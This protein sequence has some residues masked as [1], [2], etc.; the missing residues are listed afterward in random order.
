VDSMGDLLLWG[1]CSSDC[2][3]VAETNNMYVHPEN[4]VG[5]CK[6]GVPNAKR[7]SSRIVGGKEAKNGEFPWQVAILR[8]TTPSAQYCGGTLVSDRHVVTAAHCVE[9]RALRK[10][11]LD[12]PYILIGDTTLAI[13]N[14]T[15]RFVVQASK[16]KIHPDYGKETGIDNDIAVLT[17]SRPLDLYANPNIKPACLPEKETVEDLIGKPA[18]VSGWGKVGVNQHRTAHLQKVEVEIFG[19]NNCGLYEDWKITDDML[20]AGIMQG[21]KDSCNNDSGGP[22]VAKNHKDNNGA[23]TLVGVVSWGKGCA[24]KNYPGVYVDVAHYMQNGWLSNLIRQGQMCEAP[25]S[26]DWSLGLI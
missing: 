14:D 2:P 8:G 12:K 17:L 22:L 23:A 25:Q 18:I 20:C 4:A 13:A 10:Y 7:G 6:C 9:D 1:Y 16:V 19:K 26:S 3:G 5:N 15:T 24:K 11:G 21:G